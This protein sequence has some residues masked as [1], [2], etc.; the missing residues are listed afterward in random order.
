LKGLKM[1]KKQIINIRRQ[2]WNALNAA[3]KAGTPYCHWSK[4]SYDCYSII[5]KY[6]TGKA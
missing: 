1:T 2:T 3:F 5:P 6:L 4:Q